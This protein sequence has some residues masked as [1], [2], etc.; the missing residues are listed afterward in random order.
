MSKL[1]ITNINTDLVQWLNKKTVA[2]NHRVVLLDGFSYMLRKLKLQGSVRVTRS[3]MFHPRFWKSLDRTLNYKLNPKPKKKGFDMALY[4]FYY[5]LS[6]SEG[7]IVID[8][9]TAKVTEEGVS[10][11]KKPYQEQLNFLLSKIW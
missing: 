7:F 6:V 3:G 10:F 2:S 8:S 1:Y 4:Q 11:L 9:M 5:N